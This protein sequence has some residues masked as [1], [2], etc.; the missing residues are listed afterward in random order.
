MQPWYCC[1]NI[2]FCIMHAFCNLPYSMFVI[3]CSKYCACSEYNGNYIITNWEIN[4]KA[5]I[6]PTFHTP[7]TIWD[8]YCTLMPYF[9]MPSAGANILHA[10]KIFSHIVLWFML[11]VLYTFIH[12]Y[13]H[14]H[15]LIPS[16]PYIASHKL[17]P[18]NF[19]DL[20]KN[21]VGIVCTD[22]DSPL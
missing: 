18:V 5:A 11:Q 13:I 21:F 15:H 16:N 19:C 9:H 1:L 8:W 14:T 17:T 2:Y 6:N 10:H 20:P 4:I 12:K 22:G 3:E 7:R